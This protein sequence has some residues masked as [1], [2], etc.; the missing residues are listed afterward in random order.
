MGR[1]W[2]GTRNDPWGWLRQADPAALPLFEAG[3]L[4]ACDAYPDLDPERYLHRFDAHVKTLQADAV[5]AASAIDG[6]RLLNRYLFEQQGFSG[7]FLDYYDPRN[8]YLHEVLDRKLGIP[9]SLSVLYMELGQRLGLKLEGVSFPGHFLVRLPVDGGLIVLDPFHGGK[10]VGAEELKLR[11]RNVLGQESLSDADLRGLL[12]PAE[13]RDVLVRMLGNL[14]GIYSQRQEPERALT[15]C[16][17][18]VQLTGNIE[19][20]RD[21]GLLYQAVG[22]HAAAVRDLEAYLKARSRAGDADAVRAALIDAR[23]HAARLH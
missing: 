17:R 8:S 2:L 9:I 18:L 3:L 21:R 6:L 10:S 4:M 22:A 7:N 23:G 16:D 1:R 19:E 14:K 15:V 5:T 13:R 20:Q 11:A 12:G